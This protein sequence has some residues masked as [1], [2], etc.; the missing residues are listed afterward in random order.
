VVI[1]LNLPFDELMSQIKLR[2]INLSYPR[3]KI[4]E[5][6]AQNQHH[7]TADQIFTELQKTIST[8]SKTT[9]YNTLHMLVAAGLV[10]MVT[11]EDNEARYDI[12]TDHHGH[13]KC[14]SCQAVYNFKI[15]I[16]SLAYEDLHDFRID[17]KSV[18]FKGI[19]PRCLSNIENTK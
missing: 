12:V 8:L 1:A 14:L 6:L 15:A 17:D 10:K 19:C 5:Y 18:Y 2:S 9:V 13:F 11:I 7:P 16:E 4:V 3:V